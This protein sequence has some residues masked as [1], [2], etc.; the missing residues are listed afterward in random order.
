MYSRI[1]I[2]KKGDQYIVS[3][4]EINPRLQVEH[5]VTE[6]IF[7]V[8]LPSIQVM[9][10]S[11]Y[12][13]DDIEELKNPKINGHA[14]SVRINSE[15]PYQ[16]FKPCTGLIKNIEFNCLRNTWGYFSVNNNSQINSSVDNQFGHLVA[17]AENRDDEIRMQR[18]IQDLNINSDMPNTANFLK[19]VMTNQVFIE[20]LHNVNWLESISHNKDFDEIEILGSVIIRAYQ[21]Y[22]EDTNLK[23]ELLKNGHLDIDRYLDFKYCLESVK[24]N[25]LY[26]LTIKFINSNSILIQQEEEQYIIKY[27]YLNKKLYLFVN[28]KIHSLNVH[29]VDES[30]TK[31]NLSGKNKIIVNPSNPNELKSTFSGKVN[32]LLYK[33]GDYVEENTTVL[34]LEIMKMIITVNTTVGKIDYQVSENQLIEKNDL[35]FKIESDKTE[36]KFNKCNLNLNY[37]SP[38]LKDIINQDKTK[39]N[40]QNQP[41]SELEKKRG[42]C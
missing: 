14:I 10:A 27:K 6:T 9:L 29:N 32:S 19:S 21:N 5:I 22:L 16:K 34:T 31:F 24:D 28:N 18:F 1:F 4:M 7:N 23:E 33:N 38:Y 2:R 35:L 13:I 40:I 39:K 12:K 25:N 42:N 11:G 37:L 15:D 20:E 36:N 41:L 8:N 30:E 17:W 3:F 26:C